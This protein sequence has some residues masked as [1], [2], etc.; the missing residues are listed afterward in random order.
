MQLTVM[1]HYGNLWLND[2]STLLETDEEYCHLG[3]DSLKFGR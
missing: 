2:T 3:C 1:L